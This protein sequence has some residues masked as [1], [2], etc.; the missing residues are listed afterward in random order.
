MT[1]SLNKGKRFERFVAKKLTE[2]TDKE[3][4][5]VP[6]SGAFSTREG[7]KSNVFKGDVFCEDEEFKDIV[8]ECKTLGKYLSLDELFEE[9]TL[10]KW[11]KQT[12]EEAGNFNWVLIFKENRMLVKGIS[13]DGG[14]LHKLGFKDFTRIHNKNFNILIGR[15]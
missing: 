3:F 10:Y 14:L 13:Q 6:L 8:I 4:K 15:W 12:I 2:I 7:T 1:K 9:G 5:R 11:I